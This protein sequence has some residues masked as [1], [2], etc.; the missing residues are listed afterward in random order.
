MFRKPPSKAQQRGRT[1]LWEPQ[2]KRVTKRLRKREAANK[3]KIEKMIRERY[4]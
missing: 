4:T 2:D 1:E 3:A